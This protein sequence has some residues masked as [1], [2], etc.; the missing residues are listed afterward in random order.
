MPHIAIIVAIDKNNAIGKGN[1]LLYHL[2]NDLKRFKA[3]TTGN[4]VIMGRNTFESLPKGALPNRRNIVLSRQTDVIFPG[5]EHF[6]SLEE[7]LN[8]C[9][10]N[11]K[12]FI[13]GGASVYRDALPIADELLLTKIDDAAAEADVYFPPRH[14]NDWEEKSEE[15][16]PADVRHTHP[17]TFTDFVRKK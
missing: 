13:I 10:A 4:T 1:N 8:H 9:S 5:A 16:H 6:V 2:P 3:L 15:K 14:Y 11:E 7:A 12:V 17:Y